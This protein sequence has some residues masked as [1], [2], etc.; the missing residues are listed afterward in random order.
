MYQAIL[1]FLSIKINA[2]AKPQPIYYWKEI[3]Q[4]CLSSFDQI[5]LYIFFGAMIRP[6]KF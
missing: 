3:G 5:E 1:P 4:F 2:K 6:F